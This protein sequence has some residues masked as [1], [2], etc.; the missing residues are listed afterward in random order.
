MLIL[1]A[2]KT[3]VSSVPCN[4]EA[5]WGIYAFFVLVHLMVKM[6]IHKCYWV[7]EEMWSLSL[8]VEKMVEVKGETLQCFSKLE[9]E[10]G[11]IV[12]CTARDVSWTDSTRSHPEFITLFT[13]TVEMDHISS[14]PYS[15][16]TRP[17]WWNVHP[18]SIQTISFQMFLVPL[19]N[20]LSKKHG[21]LS[22]S[23][24]DTNHLACFSVAV[25]PRG[26]IANSGKVEPKRG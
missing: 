23:S 17:F 16:D 15:G 18:F 19:L 9:G 20:I 8:L 21:C 24:L 6:L 22:V 4:S 5:S 11:G 13:K 10:W 25:I 26:C 3:P 7:V 1:L 14:V 12:V 2:G